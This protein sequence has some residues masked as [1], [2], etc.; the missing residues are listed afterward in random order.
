MLARAASATPIPM[1]ASADPVTIETNRTTPSTATPVIIA[2]V[3]S[4]RSRVRDRGMV[5]TISS[6]PACSSPAT[7]RAP[8]PIP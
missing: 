7:V 8:R 4:S 5:A 3:F 6:S 1:S 2:A